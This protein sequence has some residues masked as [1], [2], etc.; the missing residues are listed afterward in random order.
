MASAA[1]PASRRES[2]GPPGDDVGDVGVGAVM[3]VAETATHTATVTTATMTTTARASVEPSTAPA[4]KRKKRRSAIPPA[5]CWTLRRL[6]CRRKTPMMS[7]PG[8]S[9]SIPP[10]LAPG[11]RPSPL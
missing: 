6:P 10:D 4:R 7:M 3:I 2:A 11:R 1:R 9:D 5:R 8:S